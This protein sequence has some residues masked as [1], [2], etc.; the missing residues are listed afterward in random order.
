MT[1]VAQPAPDTPWRATGNVVQGSWKVLPPNP[2]FPD[3]CAGR[4]L[5][6][7]AAGPLAGGWPH[8][9]CCPERTAGVPCTSPWRAAAAAPGEG[10][11]AAACAT[12]KHV[13]NPALVVKALCQ[14]GKISIAPSSWRRYPAK[15]MA[16]FKVQAT[17]AGAASGRCCT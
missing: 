5:L 9:V 3:L 11:P 1:A 8:P 16:Q 4:W 17:T 15:G 2:H 14:V 13:S 10:L 12:G 7:R 6:S